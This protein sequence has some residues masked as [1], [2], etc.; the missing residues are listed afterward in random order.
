[1][2]HAAGGRSVGPTLL[3]EGRATVRNWLPYVGLVTAFF[4]AV[5]I[6]G[7]AVGHERRSDLVPIRAPGD[8]IP[9][10]EPLDLFLHNSQV[11]GLVVVGVLF[12][13]LPSIA[14]IGYNA[15]LLGATV[16]DAT[17]TL[18]P[19]ATAALV[20]PHAIFE[21]PAMWLA[22][23]VAIRWMHVIW[24]TTQGGTRRVTVGRTVTETILAL[25]VVLF[26]LGI[27]AI[28]EGTVTADIARSL[29]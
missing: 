2:S 11:T 15:F 12:F 1:M 23:A 5:A 28:I 6:I 19:V 14:L 7:A 17:A 21:L 13:A 26:L 3:A 25:V 8:P 16:A 4:F 27:A 10:L 9:A 18:G 24:Q 29:A 20:L 22:G